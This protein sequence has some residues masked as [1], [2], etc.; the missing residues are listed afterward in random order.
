V[1]ETHQW[2]DPP[3]NELAAYDAAQAAAALGIR[4]EVD[5]YALLE[6][7]RDVDA[8]T[9]K[10]QYYILARKW[11]PGVCVWVGVGVWM[12]IGVDVLGG[13]S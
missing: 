11:H 10:R 3:G 1:Q 13:V 5:Y 8:A 9:L 12:W 7:S 4:P 2:V 6:V